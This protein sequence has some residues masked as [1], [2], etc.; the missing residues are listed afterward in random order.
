MEMGIRLCMG[1]PGIFV[2]MLGN[3]EVFLV[4][5]LPAWAGVLGLALGIALAVGKRER[6]LLWFL[7]PLLLTQLFLFAAGLFHGQLDGSFLQWTL[8]GFLLAQIALALLL[9]LR[10]EGARLAASGLGAFVLS[11]AWTGQ[12]IAAMSFSDVWL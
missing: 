2:Q 3:P 5:S 4:F 8:G 10:L 1:M 6:R 11:Y 12:F 9:I 7:L